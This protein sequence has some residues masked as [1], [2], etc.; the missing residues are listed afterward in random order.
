MK[1]GKVQ[2][3]KERNKV[4]YEEKNQRKKVVLTVCKVSTLDGGRRMHWFYTQL[5]FSRSMLSTN[6]N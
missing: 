6:S 2:I 4:G 3:N 5:Q 1:V